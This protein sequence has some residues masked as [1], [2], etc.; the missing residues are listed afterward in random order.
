ML[1]SPWETAFGSLHAYEISQ[2]TQHTSIDLDK[3]SK[4]YVTLFLKWQSSFSKRCDIVPLKEVVVPLMMI[5]YYYRATMHT[6]VDNVAGVVQ[7]AVY[8]I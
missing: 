6:M 2:I 3:T 8:H 7:A 1:N 5:K 4:M